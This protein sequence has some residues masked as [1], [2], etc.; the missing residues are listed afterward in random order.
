MIKIWVVSLRSGVRC[1][2]IQRLADEMLVSRSVTFIETQDNRK[3]C[4]NLY[5]A[6][7]DARWTRPCVAMLVNLVLLEDPLPPVRAV[8]ALLQPP[9]MSLLPTYY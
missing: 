3:H 5:C 2:I 6:E 9:L 1:K 8:N 4:P 7:D